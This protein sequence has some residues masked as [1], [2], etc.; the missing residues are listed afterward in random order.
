ML[1]ITKDNQSLCITPYEKHK[2]APVAEVAPVE[3][4]V[5][6]G[7]VDAAVGLDDAADVGLADLALDLSLVEGEGAAGVM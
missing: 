1:D 4:P 5:E 6:A 3:G 7:G 2:S